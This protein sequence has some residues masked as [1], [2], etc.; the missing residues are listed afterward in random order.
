[1]APRQ[2][3]IFTRQFAV[4][5][6]AG[7]PLVQC[8][9]LLA[10]EEPDRHLAAAV[11]AVRR[12]VERGAALADAMRKQAHV[13]DVLYTSMV[14]A[15]EASGTLDVILQ[16][17]AVFI[18]KRARLVSQLRSAMIYPASVLLVASAVIVVILWKVVPTFTALFEGLDATLPLPT[19]VVI[20]SS[21]AVTAWLPLAAAAVMAAGYLVRRYRSAPHGRLRLDA[22]L[23]RLPVL[24][25]ILRK[26]AIA[27]FCRTLST[28]IG[29]GVAILDGLDITAGTAGNAVVE[30][31]IGNVRR[32]L[33]RGETLAGPL[34]ATAV[35]P[36]M[37]S[38]MIGAGEHTGALDGMLA[39]IAEF[40]E[41]E[42]DV[43]VAGLMSALE[44]ALICALG[45]FVGGIVVSMYLPLF[46]LIGQLS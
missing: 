3:A 37:V 38:Q 20:W 42:V 5:V 12:D 1:V 13:F 34:R 25:S 6:D 36:P 44:P 4:M 2:L 19:R 14:A 9:D 43:D 32:R 40:Y 23:L 11:V 41:S 24:G 15:G 10:G 22:V 45:I 8:L 7:L 29:A 27:R 39:K 30:R 46:D 16:R 28:L 35:F 17:L 31:A 21:D 18:E 26:V 33:E